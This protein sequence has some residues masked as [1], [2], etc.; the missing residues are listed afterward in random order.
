M[1]QEHRGVKPSA[2]EK[3]VTEKKPRVPGG[4]GGRTSHSP[5]FQRV[6]KT[7]R[8]KAGTL[9]GAHLKTQGGKTQLRAGRKAPTRFSIWKNKKNR[10]NEKAKTSKPFGRLRK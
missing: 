10:S 3:M 7:S 4:K 9:G 2:V 5:P 6:L 1:G 8:T